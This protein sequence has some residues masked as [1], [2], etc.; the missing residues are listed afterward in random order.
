MNNNEFNQF[1]SISYDVK[2]II[3]KYLKP[4]LHCEDCERIIKCSE[5]Y[6]KGKEMIGTDIIICEDC[7]DSEHQYTLEC[8]FE[9][10]LNC[11]CCDVKIPRALSLMEMMEEENICN[12]CY[13]YRYWDENQIESESE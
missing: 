2:N 7:I 12:E 8:D 3:K 6:W 11:H 4:L 5:C 9:M 1:K 10:T 13:W